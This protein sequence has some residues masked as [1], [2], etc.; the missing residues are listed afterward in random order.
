P[1]RE[2]VAS[3]DTTFG[4]QAPFSQ[5]DV[6]SFSSDGKG[7]L[8]FLTSS[9][10]L[11][12]FTAGQF[13]SIS[14]SLPAYQ[15]VENM[16]WSPTGLFWVILS[17]PT[18]ENNKQAWILLAFNAKG[19]EVRRF[20][21]PDAS[22]LLI[23]DLDERG[24]C[25]YLIAREKNS[26]LFK[27]SHAGVQQPD[28]A[29]QK[30]FGREHLLFSHSPLSIIKKQ[31]RY[32]WTPVDNT[33]KVFNLDGKSLHFGKKD[34]GNFSNV[35]D[36]FFV[37]Q[38]HAWV[39]TQFGVYKLEYSPSPFIRI[40]H[41]GGD[42]L[43]PVRGIT[44]N[45]NLW[46]VEEPGR[47]L[48]KV[49]WQRQSTVASSLRGTLQR[50]SKSGAAL[51]GTYCILQKKDGNLCT[52]QD[53]R[54]VSFNPL[55]MVSTETEVMVKSD[56]LNPIWAMYEDSSGK[57]WYATD[58]AQI[59]WFDTGKA[60]F[61]PPLVSGS[62]LFYTYQFFEAT[63]GKVWLATQEG[64]F[65]LDTKENRITGRYWPRGE[66]KYHFPFGDIR[67]IHEDTDSSFWLATGETGL[68]HWY[69][70]TG[71]Y[72]QFTK[73]DG[74][75]NNNLHAVYE[76]EFG[77][78]WL[79]S[80]YGIIR[81]NKNT[82]QTWSYFEK[83]GLTHNEFNRISHYQ[84]PD[85]TIFFGGLNGV[86]AFHPRDFTADTIRFQPHLV[87]TG[88]QQFERETGKLVDKTATLRQNPVITMHPGDR[89]FRLEFS[90]LTYEDVRGIQY[91]YKVEGVDRDWVY[92]KEN[93]LRF[94]RL[95]YGRHLLH[96]KGQS[97][98]GQ[99]SQ[100]QLA[101]AIVMV[102]PFYLRTWF[103]ILAAILFL[104]SGPLYYRW[105][106][107]LLLRRQM[108]L[109]KMVSDRTRQIESDK[110]TIEHQSEELKSL[111][112]LKSR[113]F[114]NVSH[115]L[116]TPL[117]LMLGPI[118]SVL[119]TGELGNRNF[120][121]L[122]KAQQS[123]K[124]M[125]KLVASILD[126]SKL[127]SGK[128]LLFPESVAFLPFIRQTISSF[129]SHA[130]RQ[131]VQFV[132]EYKAREELHLRLDREKLKTVLHNFVSN[133]LKFTPAGGTVTVKVEDLAHS[134]RLSVADTGRGIHPD[135]LPQVFNRFYQASRSPD[136]ASEVPAGGGTGIGLA[137]CQEIAKLMEAGIW[138]ESPDPES[139]EGSVFY[140][141]FPKKE[142]LGNMEHDK[143]R[144]ENEEFRI[145][146]P[147][148][149]PAGPT[150]KIQNEELPEPALNS[151]F[152]ILNSELPTILIVEDNYSLRDY[153]ESILSP[154]YRVLTA[155]NGLAALAVLSPQSSVDSPDEKQADG[156]KTADCRTVDLILSDIMMPVMDGFQLLEKLKGS[157]VWRNIP[158]IMLTARADIS[159]KLKALRIGVDDYLLKPF[160]EEELLVR[161]DNLLKNYQKRRQF[162]QPA[163]DLKPETRNLKPGTPNPKPRLPFLPKTSNGSKN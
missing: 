159:D 56:T 113:F 148:S 134:I 88:F 108:E 152:S 130:R 114:A 151:S 126:L 17:M 44:M 87:I 84:S 68:V 128:M 99:W 7:R 22:H 15:Q 63:G 61:L 90:L 132:F 27:I 147:E 129:E 71:K 161:I 32:F 43:N 59:A 136:G 91:A 122:K 2:T 137:Y 65:T 146:N 109:E 103:L 93:T 154:H 143:L 14:I 153:I 145:E 142:M 13:H 116:R 119:K 94:S 69:P 72:E 101:I 86:T 107:G 18:D 76:D 66:G 4:N 144:M 55:T 23:Y 104:T 141:E 112:R 6:V 79:S 89:F 10:S 77:N 70:E 38:H 33:L 98:D 52:I 37:R 125:L 163:E 26:R 78:L 138:A 54:A 5:E 157:D 24:N 121:L 83:D 111:E 11:V 46:V 149:P 156:L 1:E 158:V 82:R 50:R 100:K 34:F 127:E 53:I 155:E 25:R 102:R 40:M 73:V 74:L 19:E 117:T 162:V 110:Q 120:T 95:P 58:H 96:I 140:F 41:A 36:I 67:H 62:G 51:G 57:I 47:V 16:H 12:T 92:Q 28:T 106:T 75:S 35:T 85:G 30:V 133:A 45:R 124:D 97:P 118:G 20:E 64:L 139:G 123:G 29:A 80:D 115:E 49:P 135:D 9:N 31:G 42:S 48:R 150:G 60:V 105:R 3:F 131:G 8:A 21:H 160:E 81:F 39:G